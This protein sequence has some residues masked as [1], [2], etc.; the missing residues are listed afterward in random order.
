MIQALALVIAAKTTT[1]GGFRRKP[2]NPMFPDIA[3]IEGIDMTELLSLYDKDFLAWSK[4]QA[5]ALRAARHDGSN[6]SLDWENLAEEIEDLGISVRRELQSQIRRIVRHLLKLQN[7]PAKEPRR[8][9]EESIVDARAEVEDL[10]ETSP[11]LRTGLDR[12]IER[13]SQRGITLALRDLARHREIDAAT[14]A[15]VRATLYTAE[16]VLGGWFPEER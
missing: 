15:A 16:Q 9:W 11:S 7:S 14:E 8:G 6:E 1:A 3:E 12:D 13:Q 10:L 5:E 4:Q 2:T